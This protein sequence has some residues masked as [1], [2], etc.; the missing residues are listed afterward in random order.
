VAPDEEARRRRAQNIERRDVRLRRIS[1]S[2]ECPSGE[3]VTGRCVES[4]GRPPPVV[5]R[6]DEDPRHDS[7]G[8]DDT[9]AK[10]SAVAGG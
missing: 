2:Q 5:V 10:I 8:I 4:L 7:M 6:E 9:P 3:P 1:V